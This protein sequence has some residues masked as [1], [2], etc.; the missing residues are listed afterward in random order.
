MNTWIVLLELESWKP[1]LTALVLPPVPLLLLLLVGARLIPARRIWGWLVILASVA[2]LW[3]AACTGTAELLS[4]FVLRP[5]PALSADRIK[6][7]KAQATPPTAIVVLGGG[8]E[9]FAPEYRASNLRYPSLERLRYGLWLSRETALPLAFSGGVGWNQPDANPE[10]GIAERI[11]ATEFS[12]PLKWVED[13]SRDTRENAGRSVALMKQSGI[14]HIVLVT[15]GWHM[16]RALRAFRAAAAGAV[17][18]EA[19]P[20]GLA[21]NVELPVLTWVPTAAGTTDVRHVLRE[22]LARFV[23]A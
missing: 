21:H 11:A 10:A 14:K 7:L 17:Q 3:L 19:A 23:G 20:M 1:L 15:H 16:P 22:L 8:I 9:P 6:A 2:S 4:Q 12:L 5:P 18:I 13:K